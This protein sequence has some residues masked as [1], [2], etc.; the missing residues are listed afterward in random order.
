ML[1]V[2]EDQKP[3][4]SAVMR[5]TKQSSLIA[6]AQFLGLSIIGSAP[7]HVPFNIQQTRGR[8]M[9][10]GELLHLELA[11]MQQMIYSTLRQWW[12]MLW[13]G[14]WLG[15][16]LDAICYRSGGAADNASS[17]CLAASTAASAVAAAL[18]HV[19]DQV[20]NANRHACMLMESRNAV[21]RSCCSR[22]VHF[23]MEAATYFMLTGATIVMD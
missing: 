3:G 23:P 2:A 6:K 15:H 1:H 12:D 7:E 10:V 13:G 5:L 8:N 11:G 14:L 4:N 22:D 9:H 17:R 18:V 21:R 16:E 20:C 19:P